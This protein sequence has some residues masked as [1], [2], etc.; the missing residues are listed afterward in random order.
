MCLGLLTLNLHAVLNSALL[1]S[2]LHTMKWTI[3]VVHVDKFQQI[4]TFENHHNDQDVR[5]FHPEKFLCASS[6]SVFLNT[7]SPR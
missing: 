6:Q 7:P 2:G 5:H 3:L 4:Y 1:R